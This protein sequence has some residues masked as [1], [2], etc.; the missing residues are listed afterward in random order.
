MY[1]LRSWLADGLLAISPWIRP[2]GDCL[3]G[4]GWAS[5]SDPQAIIVVCR[6]GYSSGNCVVDGCHNKGGKR[7][8]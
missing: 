7:D 2:G 1:R 6:H 8:A 3:A 4:T 5:D